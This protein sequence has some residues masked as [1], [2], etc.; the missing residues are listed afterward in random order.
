MKNY[1]T[2][3][4]EQNTL[5]TQSSHRLCVKRFVGSRF[6]I[7]LKYF[8]TSLKLKE[9]VLGPMNVNFNF[10]LDPEPIW[11]TGSVRGSVDQNE[12]K[13]RSGSGS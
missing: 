9:L 7:C 5:V 1:L 13:N 8:G 6:Q 3:N 2:K 12:E 11:K 10:R 4:N